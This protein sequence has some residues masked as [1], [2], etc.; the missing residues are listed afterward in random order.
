MFAVEER[1]KPYNFLNPQLMSNTS[2][3]STGSKSERAVW[4]RAEAVRHIDGIQ[5]N[6]QISLDFYI[7]L[8]LSSLTAQETLLESVKAPAQL[9]LET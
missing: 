3:V 6:T 2:A 7:K 9:A 5:K 1:G 8:P 4:P